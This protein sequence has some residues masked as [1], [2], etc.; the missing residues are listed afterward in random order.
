MAQNTKK[1]LAESLDRLLRRKP[2]N[3]ITI[4]DI[5]EDCKISRMT[6]YY[7]FRD[8]YD[9]VG[10]ICLE[11]GTRAVG[12]CLAYDTWEESFRSVC[13][14]ILENRGFVEAVYRSVR[15]DQI[16]EYLYRVLYHRIFAV[17]RDHTGAEPIPETEQERIADFFTVAFVGVALR[18]VK[19]GFKETPEE[20]T[21]GLSMIVNG[22]LDLAIRNYKE[23]NPV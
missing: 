6:F 7:H 5:T 17:V 22:Q 23:R 14:S 15:H 19:R 4:A 13:R 18:W 1:A 12:S 2:L 10:W 8:I 11:E 3:K 21:E 20:L 16:E 9:L